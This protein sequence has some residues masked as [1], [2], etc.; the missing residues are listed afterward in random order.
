MDDRKLSPQ[1]T[2][3]LAEEGDADQRNLVVF[4]HAIKVLTARQRE[5]LKQLGID[6]PT[7]GAKVFTATLSPKQVDLLSGKKWVQAI[8]LSQTLRSKS[9]DQ[10]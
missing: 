4:I 10:G 7:A 8:R 2:L 6:A 9:D 3:A 1:L 5:S